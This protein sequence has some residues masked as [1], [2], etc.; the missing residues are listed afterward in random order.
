MGRR[1]RKS[2]GVHTPNGPDAAPLL[3]VVLL[4]ISMAQV[5][6]IDSSGGIVRI[7]MIL[8]PAYLLAAALV[9]KGLCRVFQLPVK[10]GRTV[11]FSLGTRNSFVVLPLTLSCQRPGRRLW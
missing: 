10:T 9:G 1:L 7:L 5:S 8:F 4:I 3:T 2:H 11:V 6:Q